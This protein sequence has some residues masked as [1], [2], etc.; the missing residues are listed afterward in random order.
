MNSILRHVFWC[1]LIAVVLTPTAHA[2][3]LLRWKFKQGDQFQ[4][5]VDQHTVTEATGAG[6]PQGIDI[7]LQLQMSW[8]VASV[9]DD[10]T[11]QVMQRFDRFSVTMRSGSAAPI[12]YDS[13][14][15]G[16]PE[17]SAANIA[18][19]VS[20]VIGAEF[21]V[22][23]TSRGAIQD[24]KL[25][26]AA[27]E[28]F[29]SVESP[30]LRQLFSAEG[31]TQLLMQAAVELPEQEVKADSKW[32]ATFTTQTALGT[33]KQART[34]T[35]ASPE[36]VDGKQLERINI[37]GQLTIEDSEQAPNRS[38][39]I[40]QD[41]TGTMLFNGEAGHLAHSQSLQKLTTQRPYR[42]FKINVQT[43][44]ETNTAIT[45]Q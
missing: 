43:T 13:E 23:M 30:A 38:Q 35:V 19:A 11:A 40:D 20:P 37:S 7:K 3:M 25:S 26:D 6:K 15:D 5:T 18:A 45:R 21:A 33:L 31:I 32:A 14:S 2:E 29:G 4:V 34:Y 36:S 41:L 28:A 39:L 16:K 1:L 44:A 8:T 42:E 22:T 24:V 9:A 17:A 12:K 27:R 10:E